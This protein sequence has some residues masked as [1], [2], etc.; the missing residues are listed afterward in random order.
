VIYEHIEDLLGKI[1][2]FRT[3][4][5]EISPAEPKR[6]KPTDHQREKLFEYSTKY[7]EKYE[8]IERRYQ[9]IYDLA[10]EKL[11]EKELLEEFER[12]VSFYKQE[13][14]KTKSGFDQRINN[15]TQN[16][17]ADIG[18]RTADY[19]VQFS[20]EA[21]NLTPQVI[22]RMEL[23]SSLELLDKLYLELINAFEG[24]ILPFIQHLERLNIYIDEDKLVGY[25]KIQYEEIKSLWEQTQELAQLGIAVEIIDHQFNAL[26]SQLANII[27]MFKD[28]IKDNEKSHK[29]YKFLVSTFEHLQNNYKFLTPLYRTTGRTRKDISGREIKE[30]IEAFFSERLNSDNIQMTST[31]EFDNSVA[32]TYESILKPVFINVV[33]NAVYWLASANKKRIHLAYEE[34]SYLIMNSGQPID[35][36]YI[37][38]DIFKLFFS[39]KP[40]G[41]GIG[42]YLAKTTLNSIGFDI[43]ATN[44]KKYNSLNGACF[45]IRKVK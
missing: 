24:K 43:I 9:K 19:V 18:G 41:R 27:G 42:L 37:K 6:F 12:K 40:K 10:K 25:Y 3:K 15:I 17:V 16:F 13:F 31:K 33:N 11:K 34:D 28:S 35:E 8:L 14:E 30:Y 21:K 22:D 38:E 29:V 7:K 23:G 1:D 26:Y 2:E 39:R 4:L 20:S 36:V 44:D 5:R 45:I 32:H